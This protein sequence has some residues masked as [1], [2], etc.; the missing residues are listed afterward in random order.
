MQSE[1]NKPCSVDDN[2]SG[3]SGGRRTCTAGA[4]YHVKLNALRFLEYRAAN[5]TLHAL[6]SIAI[7]FSRP[8]YSILDGISQRNVIYA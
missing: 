4:P 3:S 6:R 1:L 8:A 2:V 5:Y 7:Q